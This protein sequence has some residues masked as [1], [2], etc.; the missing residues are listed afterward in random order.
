MIRVLVAD[1]HPVVRQGI[2]RILAAAGGLEV[3]EEA[4]DAASLLERA[5]AVE[6]DLVLLDLSMPGA[7][8]L[9]LLKQVK[10]ERPKV[11]VLILTVSS[12][13]QYAVRA[14]RAG[15]SGYLTK[16]N[17]PAEL[18]GAIRR[19]V[20]G[21]RY[22]SPDVAEALAS[23]LADDSETP[24]HERLSD[25]EFQVFHLIATG[26]PTREI[27]R[28]LGLTVKTVSTYRTRIFDKMKLDSPADLAAYAVR[29]RLIE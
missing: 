25:R 13:D 3:V 24:P 20:L 10:R 4:G 26:T 9:E 16:E 19:V 12:A 27:A 8:G 6:H 28:R 15:A 23:H 2:Q 5:R 14:L 7:E 29:H 21:G 11:P 1:D 18:V 22:V 17:A